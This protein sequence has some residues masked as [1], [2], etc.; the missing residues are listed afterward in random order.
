MDEVVHSIKLKKPIKSGQET[1]EVLEFRDIEWGD[2]M[3]IERIAK[4]GKESVIDMLAR[5]LTGQPSHVIHKLK[6]RDAQEVMD[7][8]GKQAGGF[9]EEPPDSLE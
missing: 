1:I 2:F 8:V 9:L 7:Y 6:G 3:A 5:K 4:A